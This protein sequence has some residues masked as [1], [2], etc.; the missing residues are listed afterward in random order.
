MYFPF[1]IHWGNGSIGKCVCS[2][3]YRGLK[4]VLLLSVLLSGQLLSVPPSK[5]C[6]AGGDHHGAQKDIGKS[7][8][9]HLCEFMT[10]L[11]DFSDFPSDFVFCSQNSSLQAK[12]LLCTLFLISRS[13]ICSEW[14]FLSLNTQ[15]GVNTNLP[16]GG[17]YIRSLVPGGAAERDGRMHT[18]ITA[19]Y[20]IQQCW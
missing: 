2:Q 18:G 3:T 4:C 19:K 14:R 12:Q 16:N 7:G 15:G 17:I 10:C 11:Y 20:Q 1:Y 8:P 5:L 6:E 13:Q 9:Q